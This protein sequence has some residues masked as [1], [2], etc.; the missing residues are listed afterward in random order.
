[1]VLIKEYSDGRSEALVW[2]AGWPHKDGVANRRG[3]GALLS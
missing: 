1:M 3:G 2:N